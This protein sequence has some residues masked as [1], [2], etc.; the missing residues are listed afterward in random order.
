MRRVLQSPEGS[1][2]MG[3]PPSVALEGKPRSLSGAFGASAGSG[4]TASVAV[5]A[6]DESGSRQVKRERD[7]SGRAG[8]AEES[9]MVE[10]GPGDAEGGSSTEE[11]D[12]G[13]AGEEEDEEEQ[14]AKRA[15][16]AVVPVGDEADHERRQVQEEL[17]LHAREWGLAHL[18]TP[19][20]GGQA[21]AQWQGERATR[22]S[23]HFG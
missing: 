5:D 22:G 14:G 20:G 3:P 23:H 15:R 21:P 11:V 7:G 8:D 19:R 13:E 2:T 17:E 16:V 10:D 1:E 6:S 9:G 12:Q 18:C 4:Y